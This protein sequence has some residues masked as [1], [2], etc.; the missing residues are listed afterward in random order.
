[1]FSFP[2]Y[3]PNTL[4]RLSVVAKIWAD[5]E[6]FLPFPTLCIAADGL[7]RVKQQRTVPAQYRCIVSSHIK[8]VVQERCSV[9]CLVIVT[10]KFWRPGMFSLAQASARR[11]LCSIDQPPRA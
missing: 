6:S 9:G 2:V 8:Y 5:R 4:R 7:A 10:Y 11:P 1:M 3:I